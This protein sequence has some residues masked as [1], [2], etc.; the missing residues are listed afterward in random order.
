[1]INGIGKLDRFRQLLAAWPVERVRELIY[2]QTASD[3]E[4]ALRAAS[5]AESDFAALLSPAAAK[6]L[7]PAARKA[8][9][10]TRQR[11]GRVLQFYAP[12]YVSS[13]CTNSC[14][15]CGFNCR[16]KVNRCRLTVEEALAEA[17][18]LASEGFQHLLLVAGE[19]PKGVPVDYFE[20]LIRRLNGRFS[21]VNI[22][23]YPLDTPE[24][25]RLVAAGLDSLT[26]YQETYDREAY[27]QFHPAGPKRDFDW[28]ID[29]IERGAEAGVTFLGIGALLGLSDWRVD[30]FYVGLHAAYLQRRYWRQHVSISFPRLRAAAG[31]F[32]PP[33]P[34]NDQ[35]FV[36]ILLAQRLFLPDAGMVLSTREAPALRDHLIPLGITRLSAGSR[37]SPGG[38]THEAEAEQQFQVQ[39]HRPLAEMRERVQALGFDPVCKDWDAAY[40]PL[41]SA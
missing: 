3:V 6:T 30:A 28:R 21:S 32:E 16:N 34:V 20:R 18:F 37:T 5:L 31:G 17:G 29:A 2:T 35:A 8:A 41:A 12:L 11:F 39:D 36:Q 4:R 10:L 23:I 26:L 22:E 27:A 24:Y 7:E 14:V 1:M 13:Y 19:D 9:A 40:H 15:Y 38:Y 25:A 33:F